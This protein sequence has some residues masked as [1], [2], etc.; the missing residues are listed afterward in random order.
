MDKPPAII[1]TP[2][3]DLVLLIPA[4]RTFA[5]S[6]CRNSNDADD[7]LQ[8]ALLRAIQNIDSF[9]PGS[10]MRAWIFTIMR[11]R[12]YSNATRAA[13]E[14]TGAAGCVSDMA[15]VPPTQ[16]WALRG[17]ELRRAVEALPT[18]YRETLILVVVL[19]ESYE[20]AA[21]I[22]GCDIG[23]IKSRVNRA[24]NSIRVMLGET[25]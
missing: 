7:L 4:L 1:F 15:S 19:G 6:L 2:R 20:V 21:Q 22:L 16:E 8:E 23:T 13:R 3:E 10:N 9:R 14:R 11:N 24:R 25:V 17:Q 18:H 12:F 5:R